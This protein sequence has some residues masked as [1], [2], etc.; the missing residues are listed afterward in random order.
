MFTVS[1]HSGSLDSIPADAEVSQELIEALAKLDLSPE[2][3]EVVQDE[4]GKSVIRPRSGLSGSSPHSGAVEQPAGSPGVKDGH[5]Y[6]EPLRRG[7][8]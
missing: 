3:I 1:K 6:F 4:S 8:L 2:D 7:T 5:L